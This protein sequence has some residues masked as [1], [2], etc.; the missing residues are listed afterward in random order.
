MT[1][2]AVFEYVIDTDRLPTIFALNIYASDGRLMRSISAEDFGGLQSG[3]NTYSWDGTSAQGAIVPQG[4]YYYE[5]V[6][7]LVSK[8][9]RQVGGI[10]KME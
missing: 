3:R 8:P 7:N 1:T 6:D 4:M 2:E 9:N 5:I 10:I